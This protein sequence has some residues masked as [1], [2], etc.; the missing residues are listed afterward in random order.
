MS[1]IPGA[2]GQALIVVDF[3]PGIAAIVGTEKSPVLGFD[4]GVNTVGV[5]TGNGDA[6]ASHDFRGRAVPLELLPCAAAIHRAPQAAAWAA[7]FQTP[8]G[9]LGLVHGGEE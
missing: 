3:R 6:D 8:R 9:A 2:L 7:A 4:Q 5:G 1:E